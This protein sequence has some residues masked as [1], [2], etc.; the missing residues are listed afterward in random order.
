MNDVIVT[1]ATNNFISENI[2]EKPG[3]SIELNTDAA[4][5]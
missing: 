2:S 1:I 5:R 4:L 3:N